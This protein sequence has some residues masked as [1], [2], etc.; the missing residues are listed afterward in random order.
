MSIFV[1]GII[2][3]LLN[4]LVRKI[5]GY[6]KVRWLILGLITMIVLSPIVYQLTLNIIGNY[7]GDGIGASA[8]G[9]IFAVATFING[10]VFL[11]IGLFSKNLKGKNK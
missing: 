6:N 7:S 4:I 8:A 1:M 9:L 11:F 5:A 3:I 10:L 2:L